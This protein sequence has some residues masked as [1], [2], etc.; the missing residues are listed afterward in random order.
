MYAHLMTSPALLSISET[1][2]VGCPAY[3]LR[4][5]SYITSVRHSSGPAS[6]NRPSSPAYDS[7]PPADLPS[8]LAYIDNF[9][10]EGWAREMHMRMPFPPTDV[11]SPSPSPCGP[12]SPLDPPSPSTL[13]SPLYHLASAYKLCITLYATRVLLRFSSSPQPTPTPFCFPSHVSSILS[14][15][16]YLYHL[17]RS[18]EIFKSTLWLTFIAGAECRDPQEQQVILTLMKQLWDECLSVNIQAAARVLEAI[19]ARAREESERELN[20]IQFL[21]SGNFSGLFI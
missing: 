18:S 5:I 12:L 11:S 13:S 16:T 15:L 1:M 2:F 19:W 20:W 3:I 4:I 6:T 8:V 21:D 9:N 17:P 14:H 7:M 10:P